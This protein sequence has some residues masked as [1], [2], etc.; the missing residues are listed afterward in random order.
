MTIVGFTRMKTAVVWR[1]DD[2]PERIARLQQDI[3]AL[4]QQTEDIVR[5]SRQ[6][7][8]ERHQLLSGFHDSHPKV[9]LH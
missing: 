8:W 4:H 3:P 7:V 5:T 6:L 1:H 2:L 9:S